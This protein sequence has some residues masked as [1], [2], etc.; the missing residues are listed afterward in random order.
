MKIIFNIPLKTADA[1]GVITELD[2]ETVGDALYD[3]AL[4]GFFGAAGILDP[5]GINILI[6]EF[7]YAELRAAGGQSTTQIAHTLCKQFDLPHVAIYNTALDHGQLVGPEAD[8]AGDFDRGAF[9]LVNG[10]N[11]EPVVAEV[12]Q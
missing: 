10:K 2:P 1:S 12:L 5:H 8:I 6:A 9:F 3:L 11:P 4:A 7:D